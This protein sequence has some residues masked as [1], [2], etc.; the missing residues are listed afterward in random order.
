MPEAIIDLIKYWHNRVKTI[1]DLA[2]AKREISKK[3]KIGSLLN[4]QILE[5]YRDLK[6][7]H[8]LPVNFNESLWESLLRK[9]SV[10]TLS[11]IAPV[12]VLTKP[13]PCPGNCA[14]CPNEPGMPTSYLPN[15][16]AV[17]RAVRCN[18]DPYKQTVLRLNS[19]ENNGHRPNKIEIIVIGGTWSYLP[20]KYKY[21]Y[22]LNC[23]RAAN[24][25]TR[26]RKN[27]S[28]GSYLE[29]SPESKSQ[30]LKSVLGKLKSPYPHNLSLDK[31][32]DF[33]NKEQTK[34]EKAEYKII[35]LTLETRPDYINEKEL[36]QM[37]DLGC[38]R[39]EIG[40]QAPDDE[41][42]KINNIKLILS[43]L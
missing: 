17:M 12:A 28:I 35:G 21:W 41:I 33:L 6:N 25:F 29:F 11:G 2:E 30:I 22:I 27:K 34:N 36:R 15:E 26:L 20:I 14:Y 9:R 4:S 23:F 10:R 5:V 13:Y 42:L 43:H 3:Y 8:K 1:D 16:P 7:K 38:T 39:V 32:K 31:L 37:R 19:L 24:D 18:F 40:V